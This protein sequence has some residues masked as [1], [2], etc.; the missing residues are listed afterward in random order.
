MMRT[1]LLPLAVALALGACSFI[2]E[3]QRP[4]AP[5]PDA[6]PALQPAAALG[7]SGRVPTKLEWREYFPDPRLQALIAAALEHNRDLRIALARVEEARAQ[8]GIARADRFPQIDLAA[9]RAAS[10]T[11]AD[12]SATNRQLNAQRYDVNLGVSAFELDF[13]GRVKSLDDAA[14]ANFLAS[15]YAQQSFRLALVADVASAY[16]SAIELQERVALAAATFASRAES[17]RLIAARR[18]LGVAGD[19]DVLVADAAM[20]STRAELAN[21]TRQSAAADNALRLL[22]GSSP[23]LPLGKMLEQQGLVANVPVG[24][25]AEVLLRRPDVLAAEQRLLAA[26]AN[27]GAARA[28][29]LPRILLTAALGTASRSLSGLFD[30]GSGAW[31]FAPVLRYPLFDG[32]RSAGNSDIAE[33]RK[34][35]AV[36][37][38]EKTLQQGFREIADLLAAREQYAEQLAAQEAA[39]K[40][41]GERQRIVEARHNAGLSSY[42]E[43]LDAQRDYFAAQQSALAT[44]QPAGVLHGGVSMVLA[45]TLVS[46]AAAFVV[47]PAKFHCVGQEINANHIRA[48]AEG[49]VY[50]IRP[51]AAHR[52]Q[53]PGLGS[54]DQ[55]RG[56][57]AGLRFARDHGGTRHADALP[58]LAARS[59][60]SGRL[61]VS[62]PRTWPSL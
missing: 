9:Q 16:F 28:A 7:D 20:Q 43:L 22:V 1:K 14:R 11:P 48:A 29:F 24:L 38:Y 56:R 57:Q 4:A 41:Q 50:G 17:R 55:R 12:L 15:D 44:R 46:W 45:E 32:G 37:D 54:E 51:A 42:L 36:A 31:S 2:P 19:L 21:L 25:P 61:T 34:T 58:G 53:Q 6:W 62:A 33:A 18:D 26:N 49:W 8:A 47:D 39:T 27:I 35:V 3:Y 59:V 10:L 40:A 52:A 23:T 60:Y 30:A 5:V 13:W